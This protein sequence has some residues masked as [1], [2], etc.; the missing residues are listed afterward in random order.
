[1]K[2]I[3]RIIASFLIVFG[4]TMFAGAIININEG[5]SSR[6]ISTDLMLLP[7]LSF[8]PLFGGA[9]WLYSINRAQS[10]KQF[11]IDRKTI[12]SLAANSGG[13]ISLLEVAQKTS[14]SQDQAQKHLTEMQK[15]GLVELRVTE[16]G[17]ILYEIKG[18]IIS[19]EQKD[20]SSY[21]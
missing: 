19:N 20:N 18:I 3:S 2:T 8:V 4:L 11:N 13:K 1:M 6:T 5:K 14:L 9:Y 16:Q 17:D 10:Q 7:I 12:L 21:V 15:A